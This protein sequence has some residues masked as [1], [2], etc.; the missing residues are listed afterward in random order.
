MDC[1]GVVQAEDLTEGFPALDKA[2]LI[3][4]LGEG[5]LCRI[6][7]WPP[8]WIVDASDGDPQ[9]I[10]G[11]LAF[12]TLRELDEANS[13]GELADIQHTYKLLRDWLLP[14]A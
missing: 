12:E 6:Y 2:A 5:N 9:S 11:I 4:W 13:A 10:A 3:H 7:N 8:S 14:Q 1:N